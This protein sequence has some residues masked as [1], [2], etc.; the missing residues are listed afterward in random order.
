MNTQSLS[1]LLDE[2]TKLPFRDY[3]SNTHLAIG[4]IGLWINAAF[5]KLCLM[6]IEFSHAFE[7]LE[8]GKMI[9]IQ[10]TLQEYAVTLTTLSQHLSTKID[11]LRQ[12]PE[13]DHLVK[14]VVAD[15]MMAL[16]EKFTALAA[17]S[18][19]PDDCNQ[20][21]QHVKSYQEALDILWAIC[22][23]YIRLHIGDISPLD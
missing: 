22:S 4:S 23:Q 5:G 8:Q 12:C 6:R 15:F 2:V 13:D 14:D 16:S 18:H 17:D 21:V 3:H 20:Y 19:L 7:F 11:T 9:D 10:E 1:E